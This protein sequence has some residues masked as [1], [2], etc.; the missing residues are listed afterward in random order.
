M[1]DPTAEFLSAKFI[2]K[3]RRRAGALAELPENC[4]E[5]WFR[6]QDDPAKVLALFH[7]LRL[8]PGFVLRAYQF[9]EGGNGNGVVWALPES[10]DFYQVGSYVFE[11][12]TLDLALGSHGWIP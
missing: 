6:R 10:A 3:L 2:A 5:G 12:R 1:T 7:G 9:I 11:T 4:P 8:K